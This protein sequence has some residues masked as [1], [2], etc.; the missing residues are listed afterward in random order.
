V[1]IQVHLAP[2]VSSDKTIDALFAFT[3]CEINI[4]PNCCVIEDNKPCFLT[5]S[6]VLCHSVPT[7][8]WACCAWSCRSASDELLEQLFFASLERSSSKS[9]CIRTANSSTAE[10]LDIVV[11]YLDQR[12]DPFKKDLI[13]EIIRDD[14]PAPARN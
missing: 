8:R 4:S 6:D 9:A 10:N 5:V 1:E 12:F 13:R 7:A 3:D 11:A 2:G 14:Y